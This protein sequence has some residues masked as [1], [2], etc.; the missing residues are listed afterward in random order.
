[1]RS[2]RDIAADRAS[3]AAWIYPTTSASTGE[4]AGISGCGRGV[5]PLDTARRT[6]SRAISCMVTPRS[7]AS[8]R[9]ALCSS[10]DS[11]TPYFFTPST[12]F[13]RVAESSCTKVQLHLR[14][15]QMTVTQPTTPTM[16]SKAIDWVARSIDVDPGLY[17]QV[18][19]ICAL[20][21]IEIREFVDRALRSAVSEYHRNNRKGATQ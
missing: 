1:M 16:L 2:K 9:R 7:A 14:S 19:A 3:A 17:A 4:T 15:F 11:K 8:L 18:K 13:H 5:P 20:T 6:A 10:A 12:F 21:G